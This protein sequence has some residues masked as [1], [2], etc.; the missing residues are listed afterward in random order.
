MNH[1]ARGPRPCV[2]LRRCLDKKSTVR[3]IR[4][5]PSSSPTI[6]SVIRIR[7]SYHSTSP[8]H[9]ISSSAGCTFLGT[10][11]STLGRP[12]SAAARSFA[13]AWSQ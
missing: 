5:R 10:T 1:L 8:S 4:Q 7:A 3:H 13:S 2:S 12:R 9:P 6:S 11:G